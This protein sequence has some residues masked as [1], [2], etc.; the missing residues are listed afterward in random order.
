MT[1]DQELSKD[2]RTLAMFAHLSS[3]LGWIGIP[4]A[5]IIA[6]LVLWQMKKEDMPFAA[7]EAK[8]CLNFQISITI[9]ALI[10]GLLCF[11][12]IGIPLLF[13]IIGFDVVITIMAAIKANEGQPYKYPLTIRF[14]K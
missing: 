3:F 7:T 5:N 4:L 10:A 13:A 9:Y 1:P 8:E 12:V 14:I 6:P 2:E 11:V